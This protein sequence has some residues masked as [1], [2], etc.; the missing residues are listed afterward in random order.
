[1][2]YHYR[3]ISEGQPKSHTFD[4]KQFSILCNLDFI[5]MSEVNRNMLL[6]HSLEILY[7]CICGLK[8]LVL[9]NNK[10]PINIWKRWRFENG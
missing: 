1:M 2:I 7:G 5:A 3:F 8:K 6:M 9:E 10:D 4:L